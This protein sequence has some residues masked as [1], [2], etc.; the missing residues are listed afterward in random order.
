[1]LEILWNVSECF[2]VKKK[3]PACKPGSVPIRYIPDK[4]R[5]FIWDVRYRTPLA[6]YPEASSGPLSSAS[7]FGLAPN[8]V[9]QA[10]SVARTAGEL[11]PHPFTLACA[12][13]SRAI[14]GL[15][16][17]A[18]SVGSLLPGVTRHSALWSPD[19]PPAFSRPAAARPTP[20]INLN[21]FDGI[22]RD[23]SLECCYKA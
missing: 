18:L 19:F 2:N 4:R 5:P 17:V 10:G 15:L 13:P 1:M 7:L 14:G 11:L 22:M 12:P 6:T 20:A 8:G 23:L 9:C 3:E 21:E 16:S